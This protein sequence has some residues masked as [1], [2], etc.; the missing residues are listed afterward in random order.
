[1]RRALMG[2]VAIFVVALLIWGGLHVAIRPVN[3]GQKSPV[4]HFAG[5]CWAC[6]FVSGNARVVQE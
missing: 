4:G 2:V 6:H 5:T 3:P 1:M